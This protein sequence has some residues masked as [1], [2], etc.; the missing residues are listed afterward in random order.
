MRRYSLTRETIT[1][2][3]KGWDGYLYEPVW[4]H[5]TDAAKRGIQDGDIV[6]MF[7]ERGVVLAAPGFGNGLCPV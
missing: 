4:I 3:V 6:K 1:C 5:P 2:K 7:N